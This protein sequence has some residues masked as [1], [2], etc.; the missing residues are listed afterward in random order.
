MKREEEKSYAGL[1]LF[2]SFILT[3]TIA[4]AVWN[5]AVGTRPWKMYQSRFYELEKEKVKREYGDAMM[6]FNQPDVQGKYKETQRK[7]EE[8]WSKFNTPTVQQG[9]RK[10]FRELSVLDKEKLSPLKFEAMVTRN[11][12]LEEEYLYGK[13]KS[14]EPEK[15]IKELGE[16][17][18]VLAVKIEHLEKKRAE[19]QNP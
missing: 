17:G 11:K 14:D 7:L 10:A 18:E 13:H 5:E 3:L 1:Y 15:K 8:A 9:Y 19:L 2:L 4:W 12:M 16:H 6:A